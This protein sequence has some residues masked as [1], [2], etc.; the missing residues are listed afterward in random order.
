MTS[1]D[2]LYQVRHDQKLDGKRKEH[3]HTTVAFRFVKEV[4]NTKAGLDIMYDF[5]DKLYVFE[6]IASNVTSSKG[7]SRKKQKIVD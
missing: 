4:C 6:Y 2:L 7:S 1:F 5:V 3:V